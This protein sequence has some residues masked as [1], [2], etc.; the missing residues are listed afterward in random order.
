MPKFALHDVQEHPFFPAF[1]PET[2]RW[3]VQLQ[4]ELHHQL[5][6]HTLELL[7]RSLLVE[8]LKRFCLALASK[9][10]ACQQ[11]PLIVSVCFHC[12][13]SYISTEGPTKMVHQLTHKSVDILCT[14]PNVDCSSNV[15]QNLQTRAYRQSTRRGHFAVAGITG[16]TI[17]LRK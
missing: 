5:P 2:F 9:Q 13:V 16:R 7:C 14:L 3:L 10:V 6:D 15:A 8:T 4:R 12:E 17:N 11:I 1:P